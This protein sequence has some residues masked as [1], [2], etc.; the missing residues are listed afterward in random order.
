[1]PDPLPEIP[2]GADEAAAWDLAGEVPLD[3]LRGLGKSG[4][5]CAE[6]PA[7]HGGL[8][9][10]SAWTGEFTARLGSACSSVRSVLTS[11]T[12]AA[13]MIARLGSAAQRAEL[14]PRLVSGDLAAAAFSEPDAGSDLGA[15]ATEIRREG[16]GVVLTGGKSWT[17]AARYADLI[18]V[19]GRESDGSAAAVVVPRTAP[20]LTIT[21]VAHPSGCRAAGHS[22]L[23][24]D[25]VRLPADAVLG[26]G[27][28][29]LPLLIT[30]AIS[31][32][33]LSVAW[34]CVGI[35]RACLGAATAHAARRVQFGKPL[36]QH[37]LVARHLADLLV[38]ERTATLACEAASAK[39]DAR[40]AGH[41]LAT[42]L[43]KQVAA[44]SAARAS[45]TAV[46]V[47]GSAGAHDGHPVARA[48][49]DAKLMEIIEGSSEICSL[50][51]AE[52]ALAGGGQ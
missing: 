34:G 52:H 17:T 4:L 5:L 16:D 23:A 9:Q 29:P 40:D 21:P 10:S 28:L 47:L 26:G 19:V 44:T 30:A 32:G 1:M 7:E 33:R 8:G 18:V 24:I 51:L 50:L 42:V 35:L 15:I 25:G 14:L 36:A 37:Q 22:D 3:V 43:A 45:A 6:V 31:P 38:A 48:H 11:Q 12:I 13:G 49:R 2:F 27:G 20:G 39:V 41:V 46:Q